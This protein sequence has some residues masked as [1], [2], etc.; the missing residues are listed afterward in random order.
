[1]K[2]PPDLRTH[3]VTA[4]R[5]MLR[6][7]T[8]PKRSLTLA[9]NI[10]DDILPDPIPHHCHTCRAQ[11]VSNSRLALAIMISALLCSIATNHATYVCKPEDPSKSGFCGCPPVVNIRRI[12]RL[13]VL[14]STL[15]LKLCLH[16]GCCTSV[17]GTDSSLGACEAAVADIQAA[18]GAAHLA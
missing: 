8:R 15:C 5:C 12:L 11:G 10:Q 2:A 18:L 9:G 7:S 13:H 17:Q 14:L 4:I 6:H 16:A 1:L 3:H